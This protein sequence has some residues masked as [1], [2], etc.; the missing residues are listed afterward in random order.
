MAE[1]SFRPLSRDDLPQLFDWL[2]R[3][4]VAQW[5]RDVPADL[6]VVEAEYGPCID[7]DDPTELF[8]VLPGTGP[9]G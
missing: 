6:G 1:V 5:W 8:V 9:S 2:R 7:G 3:P 4:H